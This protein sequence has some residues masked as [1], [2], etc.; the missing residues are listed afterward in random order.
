MSKKKEFDIELYNAISILL[1]Q[2]DV[3]NG[4]FE[5]AKKMQLN[6]PRLFITKIVE[7][8]DEKDKEDLLKNLMG[9]YGNYIAAISLK[10]AGFNVENEE[11]VLVYDGNK[12]KRVDLVFSNPQGNKVYCEVKVARQILDNKKTYIDDDESSLKDSTFYKEIKTYQ[13]IGRKLLDQVKTLKST[14]IPVLVII[15]NDCYVDPDIIKQL[16]EIDVNIIRLNKDVKSLEIELIEIIRNVEEAVNNKNIFK[17][18]K[19]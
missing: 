12:S 18:Y 9:L 3:P 16:K 17:R 6:L 2:N 13:S 19:S 10:E 7:S 14:N 15:L 4:V 11:N 5:L 1:K 8:H